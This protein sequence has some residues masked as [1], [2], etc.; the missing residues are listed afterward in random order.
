M[1]TNLR[2]ND[3]IQVRIPQGGGSVRDVPLS[4]LNEYIS[5]E[6]ATD[7]TALETYVGDYSSPSG[8]EGSDIA[9][10]LATVYASVETASTGI[11]ARVGTYGNANAI[12][13]GTL[14]IRPLLTCV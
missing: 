7:I 8:G 6:E 3:T 1:A 9:T 13:E 10:D 2:S 11:K 12:G 14:L 4:E 5:S